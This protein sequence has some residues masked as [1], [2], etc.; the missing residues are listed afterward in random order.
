MTRKTGGEQH[1]PDDTI[2]D[3]VG[4]PL[5][6]TRRKNA[7]ARAVLAMQAR[8]RKRL[9]RDPGHFRGPAATKV[10]SK[11]VA[12]AVL[13]DVDGLTNREIGERLGVPLP[14]DFRIKAD[15]PRVRKMVGR[16]RRTLKAALGEE[17]WKAHVRVMKEEAEA[18]RSR[19]PVQ[20]QAELEAEA[21]GVPYDEVL[22]RLEEALRRR[23]EESKYGIREGV[24][25]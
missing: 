18:W 3:W 12:A 10:A 6:R 23:T 4:I 8:G 2:F 25:Y 24:A 22:R 16:G 20:R 7:F 17:G 15:H 1:P 11:D 21:L 19:S 5:L 14:T 13:R 9:R